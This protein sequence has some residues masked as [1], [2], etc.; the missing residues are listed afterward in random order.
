MKRNLRFCKK[1]CKYFQE[2]KKHAF[3][4]KCERADRFPMMYKL[5]D[6]KNAEEGCP[7]MLELALIEKK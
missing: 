5:F 2:D 7:Y 1:Y 3:I 4:V 6:D